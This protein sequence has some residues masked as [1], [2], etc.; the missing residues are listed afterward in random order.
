MPDKPAGYKKYFVYLKDAVYVIGL[1]VALFG[2][3]NSK[4]KSEAILETTVKYNTETI[5][6][7]EDFMEKQIYLNATVISFMENDDHTNND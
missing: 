6:K 4:A 2:W 7:L 5:D 1:V 3:I